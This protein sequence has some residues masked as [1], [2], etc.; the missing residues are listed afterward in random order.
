MIFVNS[1]S[2]SNVKMLWYEGVKGFARG[3]ELSINNLK[4]AI[5]ELLSNKEIIA[6]IAEY[7]NLMN[8]LDND[9][10]I[11][12]LKFVI[13]EF[14]TRI[15]GGQVLGGYPACDLCDPDIPVDMS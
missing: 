4:R 2:E 6:R 5:E 3:D 14:H 7:K 15:Y 1:M 11:K 13:R 8:Q 12:H 10:Q 9:E